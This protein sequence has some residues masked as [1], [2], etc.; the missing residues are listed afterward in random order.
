MNYSCQEDDSSIKAQNISLYLHN[1][2]IRV[3]MQNMIKSYVFIKTSK[4]IEVFKVTEKPK[5]SNINKQTIIFKEIYTIFGFT[6]QLLEL[7]Y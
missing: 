4:C 5:K 1:F 2:G 6:N 3:H 7:F